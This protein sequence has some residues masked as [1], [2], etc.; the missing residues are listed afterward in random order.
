MRIAPLLRT[1]PATSPLP[2]CRFSGIFPIATSL[3]PPHFPAL[4]CIQGNSVKL[5]IER[6]SSVPV[7]TQ[8][9]EIVERKGKGHPDTICDRAAE[10]LSITLSRYYLE[11]FGRVLHHNVDKCILAGGSSEVAFGGGRVTKPIYL[12][13]VGRATSEVGGTPVPIGEMVVEGT[14]MWLKETFRFLDINK[15]IEIE[16]R[17]RPGSIDLVAAFEKG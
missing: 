4:Y 15:D 2:F 3:L 11:R 12:L 16:H 14:R 1:L 6:L 8:Q 5:N 7:H 13:L 9:V 10:E 17:I